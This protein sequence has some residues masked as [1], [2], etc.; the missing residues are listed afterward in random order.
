MNFCSEPRVRP[1]LGGASYYYST[2]E[3]VLEARLI[4]KSGR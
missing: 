3:I 2:R 4:L 1:A